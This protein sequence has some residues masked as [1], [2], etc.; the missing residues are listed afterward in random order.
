M[1]TP[2]KI[3]KNHRV[4]VQRRNLISLPKE[5]REKLKIHEGDILDIRIEGDRIVME[6]Y[7]LIPTSQSYFWTETTQK[8][9]LEAKQDVNAGKVREFLN[10]DDFM[11]GLG[12]D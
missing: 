3:V 8:D 7:K 11:K 5:I 6:P 2:K 1:A 9:M 12:D 10:I 4:S